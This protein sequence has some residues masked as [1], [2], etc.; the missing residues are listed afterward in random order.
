MMFSYKER[1]VT[2]DRCCDVK[3]MGGERWLTGWSDDVEQS[4]E[5]LGNGGGLPSNEKKFVRRNEPKLLKKQCASVKIYS[6]NITA[7][8]TKTTIEKLK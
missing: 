8:T 7:S 4:S 2:N 3:Y 6:R 5:D 1:R